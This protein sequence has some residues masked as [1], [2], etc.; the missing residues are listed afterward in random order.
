MIVLTV[1]IKVTKRKHIAESA[2]RTFAL[3]RPAE[4]VL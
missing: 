4:K 1:A 2:A 3:P